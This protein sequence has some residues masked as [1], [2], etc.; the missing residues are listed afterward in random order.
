MPFRFQKR[1]RIAKGVTL[2]IGKKSA[3]VRIGGKNAGIT[4]GT[5]GTRVSASV[6]G[7]GLGIS[8]KLGTNSADSAASPIAAP[9]T[10]SRRIPRWV[11]LALI[12]GFCAML[13]WALIAGA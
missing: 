11:Y 5:A 10:P 4:T 7:T 6:P 1:V 13:I 3:S 2:N 9:I 12:F 8:S